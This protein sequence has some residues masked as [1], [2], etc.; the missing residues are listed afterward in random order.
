MLLRST[1]TRRTRASQNPGGSPQSHVVGNS[2][3]V[4]RGR[5]ASVATDKGGPLNHTTVDCFIDRQRSPRGSMVPNI[6]LDNEDVTPDEPVGRR[7]L[8]DPES[9]SAGRAGLLSASNRSPRNSLVPDDYFRSPRGS[10]VPPETGY[11]R[12]PRNSLVPGSLGHSRNSLIPAENGSHRNSTHSLL[13]EGSRSPRGSMANIEFDRSPRGSICPEMLR[14][15]RGSIVPT[16][17]ERSPRGSICP[18]MLRSPRGSIAPIEI[19]RTPRGS[20]I[21][22]YHNQSPRGSIMPEHNRSPRGSI[23]PDANRSPR[24]SICPEG[25]RSPRGSIGPH[26]INR[27]PRGSLGQPADFDRTPRGSIGGQGDSEL[28]AKNR[29]PRGSIG[30]EMDRS[31][32]GSLGGHERRNPRVLAP[33]DTRR[34]SA[35]QGITTNRHTSP[36][37]H[38]ENTSGNGRAAG[39]SAG[40]Q[41]NLGYGTNAWADSRRASSS[42]SQFSGDESRRLCGGVVNSMEKGSSGSGP[43]GVATYGTLVFQL[44]DAHR[45]ASGTCDFVFRAMTVVSRTMVF[46][47]CLGCLSTVPLLMLIMGV[48]FIKDCPIEP[49]IPVYMVVGG[50]L[51]SLR[52]FWALY[53]QIQSR[54][55]EVLSVPTTESHTSPMKLVSIALS[56]FLSIWFVVGN[57]WILNIRWPKYAADMWEPDLWCDKTLYTFSVVHLGIAYATIVAS[58]ITAIALAICRFFACPWFERYK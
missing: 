49:N 19:D 52:M 22:E 21:L 26:D 55:L 42:V 20:V 17:L 39:N 6:A 4:S 29:S 33:Q 56:L 30:P 10:L 8:P 48:Q 23:V 32:R 9:C 12:S 27:S 38:R 34:A 36:Y 46:T 44:K 18:E 57:Y 28:P 58:I 47:V 3:P 7:L 45:E 13:P 5:R 41:S 31:P 11:N 14:S 37:R 53:S 40:P 50:S 43:L 2:P 16:D 1:S 24:G 51:G 15:P 25:N 35:D 54:R